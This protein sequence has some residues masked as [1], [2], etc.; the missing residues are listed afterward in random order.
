MKNHVNVE[1]RASLI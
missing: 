1:Q